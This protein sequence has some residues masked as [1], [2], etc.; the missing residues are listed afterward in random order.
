MRISD[1]S[2]DV[3]S[4]DLEQHTAHVVKEFLI[5]KVGLQRR[6]RFPRADIGVDDGFEMPHR[7]GAGM[8]QR[9]AHR[10]KIGLNLRKRMKGFLGLRAIG[11]RTFQDRKSSV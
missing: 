8:A 2:S 3:C 11:D 9:I 6:R 7:A 1:W 4:S 10:L 5:A